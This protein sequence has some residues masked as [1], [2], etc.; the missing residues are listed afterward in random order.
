MN[1]EWDDKKRNSNIAKHGVDF[2]DVRRFDFEGAVADVQER[3]GERRI[4]ATGYIDKQLHR[5]V[6]VHREENI[7]VIS[8]RVASRKER[9]AYNER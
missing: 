7:R 8:L 1:F 2:V 4:V 6:Y 9:R 5:L 3:G